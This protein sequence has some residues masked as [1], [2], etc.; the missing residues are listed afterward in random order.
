ME[1]LHARHYVALLRV[2]VAL[3]DSD[4]AAE[5]VVQDAFLSVLR[6]W[7]TIR[8]PELAEVYLRRAVINGARDQLRRRRV[9]RLLHIPESV[10][11]AGPEE[12]VLLRDEHREVLTALQTLPTRQRE[13]LVLRHL[14]GLSE[15]ATAAALNIS[16]AAAKSAA[17]KGTVNLRARLTSGETP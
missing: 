2:A 7:H 10:A 14:T 17:H 16:V 11:P 15:A 12:T 6:K 4:A 9:R 13:V 3:V 8:E 5:D 1:A